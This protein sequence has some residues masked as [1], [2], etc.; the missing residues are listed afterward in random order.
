MF[1][2]TCKLTLLFVIPLTVSL[3]GT[4]IDAQNLSQDE[5]SM[6]KEKAEVHFGP[7]LESEELSAIAGAVEEALNRFGNQVFAYIDGEETSCGLKVGIMFG[8]S[9]GHG[10]LVAFHNSPSTK[11][12]IF[13]RPASG[14]AV[15]V[16]C[17]QAKV[18]LLV[19]G[20]SKKKDIF[21]G[22]TRDPDLD[23]P[24]SFKDL[25]VD[26]YENDEIPHAKFAI[27]RQ[28]KGTGLSLRIKEKVHICDDVGCKAVNQ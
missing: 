8:K 20:I 18:F 13:W 11:E 28:E 22:Y 21:G 25:R 1:S 4:K 24:T 26:F 16:E 12:K 5:Q 17:Y 23:L 6:I 7:V 19:S 10:N 27:I 9:G 14:I 2:R 15:G 3:T